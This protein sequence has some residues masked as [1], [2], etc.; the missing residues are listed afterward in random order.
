MLGI[1][2]GTAVNVFNATFSHIQH[3]HSHSTKRLP[4]SALTSLHLIEPVP[5]WMTPMI[6]EDS[7]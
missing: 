3:G 5:N 7:A 6:I 1:A 2:F 4:F